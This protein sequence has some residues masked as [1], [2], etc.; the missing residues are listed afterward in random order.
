M[1]ISTETSSL[2]SAPRTQPSSTPGAGTSSFSSALA[3]ATVQTPSARS[4]DFTSMTRQE[5]TDWM[6]EQIRTGKMSLH[7]SAPF[8]GMTMKISVETGQPID[9]ATDTTRINFIE[10]ARLGIEG[11][12][13]LNDQKLAE[14]LQSAIDAMHLNQSNKW[15]GPHLFPLGLEVRWLC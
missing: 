7:E 3:A 1:K 6:N 5:M 12:R 15:S 4:A 10:K 11:A 8:M 2:Y 13:S 14:R 9:M